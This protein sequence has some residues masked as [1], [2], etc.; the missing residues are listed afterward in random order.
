MMTFDQALQ[1]A[2]RRA[3][4]VHRWIYV[5]AEHDECGG[6]TYETATEYEA[7]TFYDGSPV[8]ATFGPDGT[9]ECDA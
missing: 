4:K 5:V 2:Q 9:M 6:R 8:V 3:R 7:D 1:A